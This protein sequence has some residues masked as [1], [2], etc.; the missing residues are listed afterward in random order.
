MCKKR[1]HMGHV[2]NFKNGLESV[3]AENA[4]YYFE[5][6]FIV[7]PIA[8][9]RPVIDNWAS[10]EYAASLKNNLPI[11]KK[12]F[13]TNDIG[14]VTGEASGV[15]VFDF[16]YNFGE[17]EKKDALE[18]VVELVSLGLPTTSFYKRG[19]K[20]VSLLYRYQKGQ[21]PTL[22]ISGIFDFLSDGCQTVIPPSRYRSIEVD[23]STKNEV[24]WEYPEYR[25][26]WNMPFDIFDREDLGEIREEHLVLMEKIFLEQ[27]EKDGVLDLILSRNN[28]TNGEKRVGNGGR[29]TRL[30]TMCCA[31]FGKQK[32]LELIASELVAYDS[33]IHQKP[34]FSD[35]SEGFRNKT[36]LQA[37]FEWVK[38]R[39]NNLQKLGKL[40]DYGLDKNKIEITE[41][42][43]ANVHDSPILKLQTPPFLHKIVTDLGYYFNQVV[44]EEIP[45]TR[46]FLSLSALG[47]LIGNSR[48]FFNPVK[49]IKSFANF[50][51]CMLREST[52]TKSGV[53]QR[54]I[55]LMNHLELGYRNGGQ[56][57][58]TEAGI[59]SM[60]ERGQKEAIP[61]SQ[62]FITIAELAPVLRDLINPKENQGNLLGFLSD[63]YTSTG[64]DILTAP[65]AG[66][67]PIT[68][69]APN[70]SLLTAMQPSLIYEFVEPLNEQGFLGRFLIARE[71][72]ED[73]FT[74]EIKATDLKIHLENIR[75]R[76]SN[77]SAKIGCDAEVLE[78]YSAAD[79]EFSSLKN[80]EKDRALKNIF[81]RAN[82]LLAKL[83][84]VQAC[85]EAW[86]GNQTTHITIEMFERA[87]VWLDWYFT[88]SKQFTIPK[89]PRAEGVI[90][91][92]IKRR[93]FAGASIDDLL[94][95]P[96][97]RSFSSS[98]ILL[99]ILDHLTEIDA[100]KHNSA[101]IQ[102]RIY[103]ALQ[104]LGKK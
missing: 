43:F 92:E 29:N 53:I 93:G 66:R 101:T 9:K 4:D 25:Y 24:M 47:T 42:F 94:R 16:D 102:H 63:L 57:I 69:R 8:A 50:Y 14:I 83:M 88:Y 5:R 51:V 21:V 67:E 90:F 10:P 26:Q 62:F 73:F 76:I 30:Y 104:S 55:D 65:L 2:V 79:R 19:K 87:R 49:D 72:S 98:K 68:L 1:E 44:A 7:V 28:T 18:C 103:Y 97:V 99:K 85:C 31:A 27:A 46:E 40:K 3:F 17:W 45:I 58:S 59:R 12:K 23:E 78:Q 84:I 35:P 96:V 74:K 89:Y 37:A 91:E 64:H 71:D 38:I 11:Y 6:G 77:K 75:N 86:D 60:F 82:H 48:Y 33:K 15:V 80:N 20:G 54:Y 13:A 95:L 36:P 22:K 61:N 81:G 52:G 100:I 70:L 32:P 41:D 34:Y 39:F 56:G